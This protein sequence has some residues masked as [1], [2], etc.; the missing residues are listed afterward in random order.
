MFTVF[1]WFAA[2]YLLKWKLDS[3][4]FRIWYSDKTRHL[5]TNSDLFREMRLCLN[6]ASQWVACIYKGNIHS[7]NI[8]SLSITGQLAI[9]SG[10]SPLLDNI[11]VMVIVW[12]LRG[13]I[14][15][16]ALC[17]IVWHNVHSQQHTYVSSSFRSNRLGLSHLDPYSVQRRLPRVVLL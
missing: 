10:P 4:Y 5:A 11:R 6:K 9:L 2:S 13:N 7:L 14:I 16:T 3:C 17:W 12:G 15:R 1:L 8:D